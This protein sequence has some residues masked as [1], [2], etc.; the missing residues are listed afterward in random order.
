MEAGLTWFEL[1]YPLFFRGYNPSSW[2]GEIG[3]LE[4]I[5]LM[6]MPVILALGRLR[7][8][9]LEFKECLCYSGRPY[10]LSSPDAVG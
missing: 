9:E 4:V 1:G 10:F 5:G 6:Y 3:E 8:E 7:P 2:E